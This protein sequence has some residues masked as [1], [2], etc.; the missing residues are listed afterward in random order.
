[1]PTHKCFKCSRYIAGQSVKC[2]DCFKIFHPGCCNTYLTYKSASVCCQKNLGNS[3]NDASTSFTEMDSSRTSASSKTNHTDPLQLI[4][5]KLD[6]SNE[7][8]STFIKEQTET[9]RDIAAKLSGL[10]SLVKKVEEHDTLLH[11]LSEQNAELRREIESLKTSGVSSQ[12]AI[13][14]T[15]LIIAGVPSVL[16]DAPLEVAS[17]VFTAL[18]VANLYSDILGVR[19]MSIKAVAS[20]SSDR[21]PRPQTHSYVVSLKSAQVRDF[22]IGKKHAKRDLSVGAVFS[23]DSRAPVFVNEMLP[24]ETYS[25]LGRT[26]AKAR[27]NGY[28]YVWVRSQ[29][30]SVRRSDGSPIIPVTGDSDLARLV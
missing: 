28:K 21:V 23:T 7:Q 26:K 25:L 27:A 10:P 2:N 18:G 30:I 1:M 15:E 12:S 11:Q 17:K 13:E 16:P 14:S 6:E 19:K 3:K 5:A 9:N 8:M 22:I 20:G 29:R 4:L 24:A